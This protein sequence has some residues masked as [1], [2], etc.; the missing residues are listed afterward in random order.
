KGT[1]RRINNVIDDTCDARALYN[2]ATAA[3]YDLSNWDDE[4][5][6]PGNLP[7]CWLYNPGEDLTV[8]LDVDGNGTTETITVP[9]SELGPKAKRYYK[10]V[11]LSADKK[12]DKWYASLNYTWAKLSGNYE[13]LVKSTNGQD[14]TGTT[15]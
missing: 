7:G 14:D 13:G 11:T 1:Y 8:T 12:T 3:G 5:T 4:W 15:S 10:A 6:V 2:A 9:G